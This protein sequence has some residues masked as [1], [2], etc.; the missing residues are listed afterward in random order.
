M[1][2]TDK[3]FA[4][5]LFNPM[6]KDLFKTYPR[7]KELF[8]E[9][10]DQ[11]DDMAVRYIISMYDPKSPF[12]KEF[13]DLSVRKQ[14]AALFAG[15]E[16]ISSQAVLEEM[17][18]FSEDRFTFAVDYFLKKF[19]SSRLWAMIVSMEQVWWGFNNRITKPVKAEKDKEELQAYEI[20]SKIGD[21]MD[22]LNDRLDAYYRRFYSDDDALVNAANKIQ[23]ISPESIAI[24]GK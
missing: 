21:E 23:R 12:I 7:L 8:P 4:G 6:K 3:D 10:I 5:C 15:Y 9:G 2:Y 20:I 1:N 24:N 22:K 16:L 18:Q 13:S 17:F 11:S 19:V 14:S